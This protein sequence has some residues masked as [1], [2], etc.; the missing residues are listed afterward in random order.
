LMIKE[1]WGSNQIPLWH[2]IC[3]KTAIF[4][5]AASLFIISQN[6]CGASAPQPLSQIATYRTRISRWV[7]K[8]HLY[9]AAN[10]P[11]APP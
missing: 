11:P 9:Q 8:L 2:L 5:P 4:Q 10:I 3:S 6:F 7:T 1:T